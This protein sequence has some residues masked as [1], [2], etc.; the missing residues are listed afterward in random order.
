MGGAWAHQVNAASA[1][2]MFDGSVED[3]RALYI[4]ILLAVALI[5]AV[6][7]Q[8]IFPKFRITS[9]WPVAAVAFLL[10]AGGVT[11]IHFFMAPT[12]RV[13]YLIELSLEI[14]ESEDPALNDEISPEQA[15]LEYLSDAVALKFD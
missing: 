12:G 10:L 8:R 5:C 1:K 13:D 7:F 14:V 9:N 2:A 11:A 15:A 3:S 4:G 6:I